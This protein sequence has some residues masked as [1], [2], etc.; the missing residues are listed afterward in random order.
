MPLDLFKS[1]ADHTGDILKIKKT[2]LLFNMPE[3]N[4]N[5]IGSLKPATK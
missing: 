3:P 1:D 2:A 4:L 5:T